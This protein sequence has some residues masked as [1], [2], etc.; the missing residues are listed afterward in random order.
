LLNSGGLATGR[1]RERTSKTQNHS[2]NPF[3]GLGLLHPYTTQAWMFSFILKLQFVL[4]NST[5][6]F[7]VFYVASAEPPNVAGA[8]SSVFAG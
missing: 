8:A 6:R 3:H 1:I 2:G 5:A 4:V 7:S